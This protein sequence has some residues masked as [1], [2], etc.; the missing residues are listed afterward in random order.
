MSYLNGHSPRLE[1][2]ALL[3]Y[4]TQESLQGRLKLNDLVV[5]LVSADGFLNRLP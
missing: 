5:R 3:D 2:Q 4:L 1:E